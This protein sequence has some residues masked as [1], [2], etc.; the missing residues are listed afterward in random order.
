MTMSDVYFYSKFATHLK[1]ALKDHPSLINDVDLMVRVRR[2]LGKIPNGEVRISR[3]GKDYEMF[4]VMKIKEFRCK[5]L[6]KGKRSGYRIIYLE[7]AGDLFFLDIYFHGNT[8]MHD[9]VLIKNALDVII[10]G[11]WTE[12][13]RCQPDDTCGFLFE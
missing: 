1:K 12:E 2:K 7:Y 5:S 9:E 3:L 10:S 8:D 11:K 6:N 13:F 4:S